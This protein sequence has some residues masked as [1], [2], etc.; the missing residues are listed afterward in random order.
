MLI[1]LLY[2]D[3][4]RTITVHVKA[5]LVRTHGNDMPFNPPL[6]FPTI[7]IQIKWKTMI[8]NK[9]KNVNNLNIFIGH[10]RCVIMISNR[11]VRRYHNVFIFVCLTAIKKKKQQ[12]KE[13]L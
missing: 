4:H 11:I 13:Q 7:I 8:L 6:P 3:Y 1:S 2:L 9:W 12:R 10:S 5:C